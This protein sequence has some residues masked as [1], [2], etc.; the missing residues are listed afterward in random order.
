MAESLAVIDLIFSFSLELL[1]S[2]GCNK[3]L[4]KEGKERKI[5][6]GYPH[7]S[8]SEP[9]SCVNKKHIERKNL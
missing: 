6:F 4:T 9:R 8:K 1:P 5:I 3:L 2:R 7:K